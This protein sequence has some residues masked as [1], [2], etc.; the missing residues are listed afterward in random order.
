MEALCKQACKLI[1]ESKEYKHY[2]EFFMVM[3][4]KAQKESHNIPNK[5]ITKR[6]VI[7]NL[8]ELFYLA[9]DHAHAHVH[10]HAVLVV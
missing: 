6:V 10:V 8:H 7:I 1:I 3:G 4:K 2:K 5:W 9:H